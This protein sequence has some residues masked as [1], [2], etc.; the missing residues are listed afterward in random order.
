MFRFQAY[1]WETL[2]YDYIMLRLNFK[3]KGEWQEAGDWWLCKINYFVEKEYYKKTISLENKLT[4]LDNFT[5]YCWL[6]DILGTM[7]WAL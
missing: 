7:D 1:V 5:F 2:V 4:K 6:L 3:I